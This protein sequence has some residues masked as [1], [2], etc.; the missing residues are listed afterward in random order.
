MNILY[1]VDFKERKLVNVVGIPKQSKHQ[2]DCCHTQ[3]IHIEDGE[4]NMPFLQIMK[5]IHSKREA[6]EIKINICRDCAMNMPKLFEE[7]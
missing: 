1:N 2:C 7:S 4:E 5:K 6:T 3:Y